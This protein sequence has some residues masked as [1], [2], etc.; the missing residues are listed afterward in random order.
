MENHKIEYYDSSVTMPIERYQKFNKYML[1]SGQVGS[2]ASDIMT[3]IQRAKGYNNNGDADGVA[4]ELSNLTLLLNSIEQEFNSSFT[5][6][7]LTVKSID[8]EVYGD[9]SLGGL[10]DTI[11]KLSSIGVTASDL[12]TKTLEIKKKSQTSL[13]SIF[14]KGLELITRL[15]GMP[16]GRI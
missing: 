14:R 13:R 8:G 10:T 1:F 12:Q 2:D 15:I 3:R 7:A 11:K 5:A 9:I 6:G 4:R 16:L